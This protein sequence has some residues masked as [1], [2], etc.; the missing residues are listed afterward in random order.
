MTTLETLTAAREKIANPGRWTQRSYAKNA[1]GEHVDPASPAACKWCADGAV[2][3]VRPV[4][5][6]YKLAT[7]VL[8][9]LSGQGSAA[10]FNDSHTHAEVLALFDKAIASLE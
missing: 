6:A 5:P 2:W 3:A 1:K 10:V 8:D 4:A 9:I 7:A